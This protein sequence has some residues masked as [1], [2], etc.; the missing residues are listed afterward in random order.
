MHMCVCVSVCAHAHVYGNL[1]YTS[2]NGCTFS[3]ILYNGYYK[4]FKEHRS[5][6]DKLA[7]IIYLIF[8]NTC[9]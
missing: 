8:L 5:A 2:I 3:L 7:K 6:S 9:S 4:C 1:L